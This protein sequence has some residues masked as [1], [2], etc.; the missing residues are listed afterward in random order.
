MTGCSKH[1]FTCSSGHCV[2]MEKRCNGALDCSDGTDEE[3]CEK[4]IAL[5]G[6]N[7]FLIP[8][9]K[10]N[11]TLFTIHLGIVLD[12][13]LAVDVPKGYLETNYHIIRSW[14]DPQLQY[15]NLGK[16]KE[17]NLML[18]EEKKK[19]WMPW[20]C[21]DN[22]EHEEEIKLTEKN[23]VL[24]VIVNSNFSF[25]YGDRTFFQKSRV[26]NGAENMIQLER[27]F[28]VRSLCDYNLRWFP[29]DSQVCK[30]KFFHRENT[31]ELKPTTIRYLGPQNLE[32]Y[33]VESVLMCS[34]TFHGRPGVLV[35]IVLSRPI[36]ST[37]LSVITPTLTF[38]IL[39]Q[40]IRKFQK[41]YMNV[42]LYEN[43]TLL[44]VLGTL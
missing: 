2:E 7:K 31:I 23:D 29:F 36:L 24:T 1:E 39:S 32:Q 8:Q 30:M 11:Q 42:V 21:L 38:V 19:I 35:E 25:Q 20:T 15:R 3:D 5:P 9:A 17:N 22:I 4:I 13:I 34:S 41:N 10:N 44:L 6:H 12:S 37:I 28:F 27:N 14:Y 43:V 16:K 33:Y 26:F 40:L 18:P